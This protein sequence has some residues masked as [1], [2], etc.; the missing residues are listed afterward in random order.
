M[1][2]VATE[3]TLFLSHPYHPYIFHRVVETSSAETNCF[4]FHN[5]RA[6]TWGV[7]R[8]EAAATAEGRGVEQSEEAGGEDTYANAGGGE[9]EIG[10]SFFSF[11]RF[12]FL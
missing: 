3:V 4:S 5:C 7:R 8:R 2:S 12:F 10:A 9:R 1:G 6:G 11:R